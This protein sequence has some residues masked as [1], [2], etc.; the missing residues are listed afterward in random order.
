MTTH[1]LPEPLYEDLCSECWPD[2]EPPEL[3]RFE[4]APEWITRL[5]HIANALLITVA[6]LL[7]LWVADAIFVVVHSGRMHQILHEQYV[8]VAQD[9]A[10]NG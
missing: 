5:G 4:D 10:A 1:P 2:Q 8:P 7:T 6:I 3:I 9:G